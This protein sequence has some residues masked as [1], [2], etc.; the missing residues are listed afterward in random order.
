MTEREAF[1]ILGLSRE[2]GPEEMKRKYR[3]MILQAHPDTDLSA[4]ERRTRDAQEINLAYGVLK[5]YFEGQRKSESGR[6]REKKSSAGSERTEIWNAEINENAYREREI[7][8]EVEDSEGRVMGQICIARGKYLWSVEESFSLFLLSIYRCAGEILEEID[9]GKRSPSRSRPA[10][11]KVRAELAYLLAQQFTDSTGL[12]H[13]FA[14]EETED[15]KKRKIY[16]IAAMV[17]L[18]DPS[19]SLRPGDILLPAALRRH[20]LYLR[21]ASGRELGYL[22]FPD[23]RLY[24]VVIPLFEQRAA[25]VRIQAAG[26][27]PEAGKRAS[28]NYRNLDLWLRLEPQTGGMPEN[29]NLQIERLLKK[30][31]ESL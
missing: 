22:S 27:Q 5:K 6:G 30:Y 31:R 17:E 7:L 20:R 18:S 2:D 19:I 15:R 14:L 10:E 12:L 21:D 24:Y 23:D 3:R 8:H 11:M 16:R 1:R 29:L 25:R 26:K 13:E 4:E 28:G 9:F